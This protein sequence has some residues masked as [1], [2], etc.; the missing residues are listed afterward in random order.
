MTDKI[1][2]QNAQQFGFRGVEWR[3]FQ[4]PAEAG[5]LWHA[6]NMYPADSAQLSE[7]I[8]RPGIR[9][10]EVDGLNDALLDCK[11]LGSLWPGGGN[12]QWWS[13]LIM[14][15]SDGSNP[16]AWRYIAHP[17]N[18][19]GELITTA[20]FATAGVVMDGTRL[21]GKKTRRGASGNG[22][23]IF[24]D[25]TNPPW[26]WDGVGDAHASNVDVMGNAPA[27]CRGNPEVYYGKVFL[28]DGA[29][30]GNTIMWSEEY[31]PD[32][33]YDS[34]IYNNTWTLGQ[35]SSAPLEAL[36][37]TN[38]GLYYFRR[39]AIGVIFGEATS[40]FRTTGVHDAISSTVG[41]PFCRSVLWTGGDTI[42]FAD[43]NRRPWVLQDFELIPIW[44]KMAGYFEP[45]S[46]T[47]DAYPWM[48]NNFGT[49]NA[50]E[51]DDVITQYLPATD[52][53]VFWLMGSS[54]AIAHYG[55][56]FDRATFLCHGFINSIHSLRN[57]GEMV[58]STATNVYYPAA[59]VFTKDT[60][61]DFNVGHM[62]VTSPPGVD[63]WEDAT[64]D[65]I[66]HMTRRLVYPPMVRDKFVNVVDQIDMFVKTPIENAGTI[67]EVSVDAKCRLFTAEAPYDGP[68]G[69]YQ[70]KN[71]DESDTTSTYDKHTHGM[72][73][74]ATFGVEARSRWVAVDMQLGLQL[75]GTNPDLGSLTTL[76]I[77]G[78]NTRMVSVEEEPEDK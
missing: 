5:T 62:S 78:V 65:D 52:Q 64:G 70:T 71:L 18:L 12:K 23:Y 57:F 14:S 33:G 1:A 41:T 61:D 56:V 34:G 39:N 15:E 2:D 36:C 60:D 28:I 16:E 32:T 44:K 26:W 17:T 55:I 4:R 63:I 74:K 67:G 20:E 42:W 22:V 66:Q 54:G 21:K 31:T 27:L 6:H 24:T 11:F 73:K 69:S 49:I 37:A 50:S 38:T 35:T 45:N 25:E 8:Q 9:G 47:G 68:A 72:Y 3:N 77:Q 30:D 76:A 59:G 58:I 43:A 40:N 75:S 10:Y 29:N 19:W 53:V 51:A 46:Q 13:H 7:Y 48:D